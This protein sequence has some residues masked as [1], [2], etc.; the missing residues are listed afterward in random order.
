[1]HNYRQDGTN[2]TLTAPAGGL[3]SGKIHHIGGMVTVAVGNADAGERG[4]VQRGCEITYPKKTGTALAQGADAFLHVADDEIVAA[5]GSG[6]KLAGFVKDAADA[7]ADTCIIVLTL[8][9]V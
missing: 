2:L 9:K 6:I 7:A 1:M 4:S 5:A 3:T 8:A